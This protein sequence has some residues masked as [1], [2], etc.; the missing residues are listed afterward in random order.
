MN[1]KWLLTVAVVLVLLGALLIADAT[2]AQGSEPPA[3]LESQSPLGTAFTYQGQLKKNGTPIT[4]DCLMTFRLYDQ[5]NGGNQIGNPIT[6][7]VPITNGL[8]TVQLAF[9]ASAF[10][11]EAR[12]LNTKVRCSGDGA[13]IDLGRQSLTAVPYAWYA[14]STGAL[15]GRAVASTVPAAGQVLKFDGITWVPAADEIGAPG[16]GDISAV[17]AGTGLSGGGTS[18]DVT[19]SAAFGGSGSANTVARSDHNHNG[20]YALTTHT[21]SGGDITSAV[22]N[23]TNA[24]NASYADT[25]DGQHASAFAL[26]SHNHWGASWSGWFTG[27]TL[28]GGSIGL[29]ASGNIT[30]VYA[31][32]GGDGLYAESS[33]V[34]GHGVHGIARDTTGGGFADGVWGQTFSAQDGA[35]VRGEATADSG[36]VTYGVYG[37]AASANG[38]GVYG[39]ATASNGPVYGVGG[40]ASS[41]TGYGGFFSNS[42]GS[43]LEA[44][45]YGAGSSRAALR[46]ENVNTT[47]GI[48]SYMTNNSSYPT[49]EMDQQGSGR[50]I[51]LQ[52][53]GSGDFIAGYDGNVNQKFRIDA[54][55][56]GHSAGGWSTSMQDYAEMLPA[57]AGLE[58]GDVLIIGDDGQL[59]RSTQAYQTS[60]VGVYSTK[61][62]FVGGAPVEGPITGTIP[63]AIVGIVPVK[64]TAE[65]G[66]IHPGD[67]LVASSLPGHAM[68]AG[69]NPPVGTVIGKA[70]EKFGGKTGVIKV[71]VTL[72]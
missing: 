2:F 14:S 56:T 25:V 44:Y 60:V 70:L 51:D 22:A 5:A 53:W 18:G 21:H 65:N 48:A 49:L 55:G 7:T 68:K 30:G 31:T 6:T 32:S 12:W 37:S 62:G 50:L 72:R 54:N 4:D 24:M 71:L 52:T 13:Y 61:P 59:A 69:A 47:S 29:S 58:P 26:S 35:G 36:W 23:A 27:L 8:F 10:A 63:L 46:V 66:A 67:L 42:G 15:Q 28:T 38:I 57:V 34:N 45:G 11:G 1:R 64:V 33:G 3:P 16:S 43:A 20:V 39:I 17:Y 19:L 41:P 9:D 40:F